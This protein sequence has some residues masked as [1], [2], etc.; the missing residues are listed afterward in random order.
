MAQ[1][2]ESKLVK[3]IQSAFAER[4][5]WGFKYHG[6]MMSM[7]G[8]PDLIYCYKGRFV[9]VEVKQGNGKPSKIQLEQIRRI[10]ASGGIAGVVWSVDEAL[11][12]LE[13]IDNE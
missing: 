1:Q 9:G 7:V 12:L 2:E 11:E 8:V 5:A 10:K 6:G 13:R 3:K 4:G